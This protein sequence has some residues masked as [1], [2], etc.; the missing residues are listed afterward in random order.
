MSGFTI[1]KQRDGTPIAVADMEDSHIVNTRNMLMRLLKKHADWV[2]FFNN[3]L[4]SRGVKD[5]G[6]QTS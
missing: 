2:D 1:W 6:S 3:E 5:D 4:A